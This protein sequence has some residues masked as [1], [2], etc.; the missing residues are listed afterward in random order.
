MYSSYSLGIDY[1]PLPLYRS[2]PTGFVE[3]YYMEKEFVHFKL[4]WSP[5]KVLVLDS[6]TFISPGYGRDA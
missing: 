1:M 4:H 2:M 5:D 3:D 6:E